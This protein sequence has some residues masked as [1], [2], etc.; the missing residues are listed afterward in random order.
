MHSRI[1]RMKGRMRWSRRPWFSMRFLHQDILQISFSS[2]I[3][4]VYRRPHVEVLHLGNGLIKALLEHNIVSV[5]QAHN[6]FP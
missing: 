5:L 4:K 2:D 1:L 6:F 3:Q